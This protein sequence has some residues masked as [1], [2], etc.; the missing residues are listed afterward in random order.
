M[1]GTRH[2]NITAEARV[3]EC[4]ERIDAREAQIGAW[5]TIDREG[6]L[7]QARICDRSPDR[8]LLHGI[9]IGVKDIIDVAGLPAR[10]GTPIYA[11]NIAAS[12]AACVALAKAAGA[13]VLGKTVTT[14]LAF[15]HPGKTRNPHNLAHTPGGSSSG[16]AAAVAADMVTL[17]LGSQTAGS[18]IRP[19]SFCGIV[20]YKPTFGMIT[21]AGV[22]PQSDTLDTVGLMAGS[23][24]HVALFAAGITGDRDLLV[25]ATTR[26]AAR[27]GVCHTHEWDQAS[28]DAQRAIETAAARFSKAGAQVTQVELPEPFARLCAAQKDIQLFE[29]ARSYSFEYETHRGELSARLRALL[30]EGRGISWERYRAALVLAVQCRALIAGVFDN[31]DVLLM[32]SAPGEAPHGLES[33]GDPVFNRIGTVLNLPCITLPGLHGHN[34][35]PIG[36]QLM[37]PVWHDAATLRAAHWAH[38]SL[39]Q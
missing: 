36:I 12:D 16:S 6:A 23:V 26:Q 20:G 18:V 33:T 3:H 28:D 11:G 31:I 5:E 22:K 38:R 7:T 30:E 4:L 29:A 35:L 10:Y 17:A 32:P 24:E 19:A 15:F 2:I 39:L 21:R 27:I 9:P 25:T 1:S 14:E 34:G 13:I 8:G 37:G